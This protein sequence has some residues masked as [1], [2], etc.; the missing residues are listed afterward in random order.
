VSLTS[1]CSVSGLQCGVFADGAHVLHHQPLLDAASME[2]VPAVQPPKIV[3]INV[4]LLDSE[5]E[6]KYILATYSSWIGK[7]EHK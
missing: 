5:K 2:V 1:L 4:L 7:K 3:S 6:H